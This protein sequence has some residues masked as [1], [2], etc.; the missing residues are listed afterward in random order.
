MWCKDDVT[1]EEQ[2]KKNH[3]SSNGKNFSLEATSPDNDDYDVT[4]CFDR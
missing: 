1:T 3:D 2:A 4:N